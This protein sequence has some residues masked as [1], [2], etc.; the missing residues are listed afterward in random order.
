MFRAVREGGIAAA[1][2]S[3]VVMAAGASARAGTVYFVVAER[4]EVAERGD[5]FVLPLTAESD[6]AHARD[7]IARGPDA[8]GSALV[9][10]EI[11][12]G[13]DG[14]N[15]NVLAE[16]EPLWSW[17]VSRFEG[18]GD[19]GI[20]LIDGNPTMVEE[21][22]QGWIAN[23]RTAE[24][25]NVGHIGFWSYTVVDELPAAPTIPLPAAVPA[26]L[27]GLAAVVVARWW[28]GAPWGKA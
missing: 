28:P 19:I 14:I 10:A 5:S 7:L 18:F 23:T 13:S 20:E 12:A 8:A 22:V 6:I 27:I 1:I 15:R 4:P 3:L 17:H 2:V 26:G 24:N 11:S 21:D 9:F 25:D 16:G